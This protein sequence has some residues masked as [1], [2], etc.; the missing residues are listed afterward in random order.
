MWCRP[1][2]RAGSVT[3][4]TR[5][6]SA[7]SAIVAIG[8]RA[9]T[10][11]QRSR[12]G[13]LT[14]RT[15]ACS[16]SSR[17]LPPMRLWKYFGSA[18]WLRSSRTS[19]ARAASLVVSSPPS[20]NAPRFLLGKNE[21]QPDRAHRSGRLSLVGRADRLRGIFDDRHAAPRRAVVEDRVHVGALPVEMDGDDRA[22]ARRDRRV[23]RGGID[24]V[25]LGIDVDE[26][27]RRARRDDRAGGREERERRA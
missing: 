18:P 5:P 16:A 15:A 3:H 12:C 17:K 20:P 14:R 8:V 11:V 13:S 2:G 19:C 7:N 9:A 23:D 24:V 10:A 1:A 6:R 4:P 27:R 25:G 22:R 21:K 26:P